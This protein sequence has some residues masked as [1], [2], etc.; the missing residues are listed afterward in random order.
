MSSKMVGNY[1]PQAYYICV[2]V[3][4]DTSSAEVQLVSNR[5]QDIRRRKRR[6]R[7]SLFSYTVSSYG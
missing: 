4:E 3:E 7:S 6:F 1:F 2:E 5:L